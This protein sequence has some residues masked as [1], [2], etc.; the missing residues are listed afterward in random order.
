MLRLPQAA[1]LVAVL[2]ATL[3]SIGGNGHISKRVIGS[4]AA[5]MPGR[6][7]LKLGAARWQALATGSLQQEPGSK[8]VLQW[9]VS[10]LW[11]LGTMSSLTLEHD[12]LNE[13]PLVLPGGWPV[14]L[15]TGSCWRY[16]WL[17][18]C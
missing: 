13:H 5:H 18:V 11:Q 4:L 15:L 17:D 6:A 1:S 16:C 7:A 8:S 14:L 12:R 3:T 2:L 10:R 9:A